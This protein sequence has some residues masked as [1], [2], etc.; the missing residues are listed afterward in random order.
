[1]TIEISN[2]T[3]ITPYIRADSNEGEIM[4][5]LQKM[6]K[7]NT[8]NASTDVIVQ[9]L[10]STYVNYM[11]AP[12]IDTQLDDHQEYTKA[13]ESVLKSYN[14]Y[15]TEDLSSIDQFMFSI[16]LINKSSD[17]LNDSAMLKYLYTYLTSYVTHHLA[18]WIFTYKKFSEVDSTP[19]IGDYNSNYINILNHLR[20]TKC[21]QEN[22]NQKI[23]QELERIEQ[24]YSQ[25]PD[26]QR[27]IQNMKH[28][29]IEELQELFK[30]NTLVNIANDAIKCSQ[31]LSVTDENIPTKLFKDLDMGDLYSIISLHSLKYYINSNNRYPGLYTNE[32]LNNQYLNTALKGMLSYSP[33]KDI[34]DV[35][36]ALTLYFEWIRKNKL[37]LPPHMY[38]IAEIA[39]MKSEP[40][41][42]IIWYIS[43]VLGWISF[44]S[45]ENE[46]FRE[47]DANYYLNGS[48]RY[49]EHII[50]SIYLQLVLM[51]AIIICGP[52]LAAHLPVDLIDPSHT[53]AASTMVCDILRY[54]IGGILMLL[55]ALGVFQEL[56]RLQKIIKKRI[57]F[58]LYVINLVAVMIACAVFGVLGVMKYP[59]IFSQKGLLLALMGI[60][61]AW[62]IGIILTFISYAIHKSIMLFMPYVSLYCLIAM[63]LLLL[64]LYVSG[65]SGNTIISIID[66]YL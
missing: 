34:A 52:I 47:A 40:S 33:S 51:A 65:I 61:I 7:D 62:I 27:F 11:S 49:I 36:S 21:I 57:R 59:D 46:T 24:I 29:S 66:G 31:K 4:V 43:R 3:D 32:Y 41:N 19:N 23:D 25:C 53:H 55:C 12:T 18:I 17:V 42:K 48:V 5:A 28:I 54:A 2:Y 35:D 8:P 30:M 6:L 56:Q 16:D 26:Y 15:N 50:I 64:T 9:K 39:R 22:L 44:V 45:P 63:F 20:E 38:Q 1:M 10:I 14:I 58:R 37:Y 13:L 60:L